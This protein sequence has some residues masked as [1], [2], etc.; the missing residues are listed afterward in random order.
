MFVTLELQIIHKTF[1]SMNFFFSLKHLSSFFVFFLKEKNIW[2]LHNEHAWTHS[3]KNKIFIRKYEDFCGTF[4]SWAKWF[5]IHI[6]TFTLCKPLFT[7]VYILYERRSQKWQFYF[8]FLFRE[9]F[10]WRLWTQ[11]MCRNNIDKIIGKFWY[12]INKRFQVN[13]AQKKKKRKVYMWLGIL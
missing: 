6:Q 5:Y 10:P 11:Y 2:F 13:K 4:C 7:Q 3:E 12:W 9:Q 1:N 8:L